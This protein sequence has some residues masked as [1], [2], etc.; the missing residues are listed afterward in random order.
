M[1]D[2]A[3]ISIRAGNGGEGCVSFRREKYVPLGGPDGGDGGKGGDVIIVASEG[4]HMLTAFRFIRRFKAGD[5]G[6]GRGRLKSGKSGKDCILEVP[7]GTIIKEQD[8]RGKEA[9]VAD[10]KEN[11]AKFVLAVGGEGGKGNK[12]FARSENRTPLLAE[13]GEETSEKNLSLELQVLADVGIIGKPSVGKSSILRTC[14]RARPAVA[15]YPFTTLEPVLGLVDVG[16]K[17]FVIAEIPGLIEGAH[18][19]SGLGH[20]FLRHAK[21]TEGIVHLLD[22]TSDDLTRDYNQIKEEMLMYDKHLLDKWEVI[23]V[24]KVDMVANENQK[25]EIEKELLCLLGG[26]SEEGKNRGKIHFVSAVSGEGVNELMQELAST[27]TE[28]LSQKE[29]SAKRTENNPPVITPKPRME[30]VEVIRQN[31]LFLVNSSKAERIVRKAKTEDKIILAQVMNEL[32]RLGVIRALERAGIG[33]GSTVRIG[34]W[35]MEWE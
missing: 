14:S 3:N 16:Y 7:V 24:N 19:G 33:S 18:K 10:L 21:R 2:T 27:L 32:K 30:K 34:S 13:D 29:I 4:H 31:K 8:E 17:T 25:Q 11:G 26:G 9:I 15:D 22:G 20:E 12:K 28:T 35:E 1:I 6:N 5:G 23:A